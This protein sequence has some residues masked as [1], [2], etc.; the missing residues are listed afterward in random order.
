MKKK[1][2][3]MRLLSYPNWKQKLP[4][5]NIVYKDV[6][7]YSLRLNSYERALMDV[8][9]NFYRQ[10]FSL[11][12]A[13]NHFKVL[14]TKLAKDIFIKAALKRKEKILYLPNCLVPY[15]KKK[16]KTE[17]TE[18]QAFFEIL[19]EQAI[20]QKHTNPMIPIVK[21]IMGDYYKPV[22]KLVNK[23]SKMKPI[24]VLQKTL[25]PAAYENQARIHIQKLQEDICLSNIYGRS[26]IRKSVP[27]SI[28]DDYG[29]G[30]WVSK[31]VSFGSNRLFI[32]SNNNKL[33]D[34]ALEHM[35]YFN[36]YPGY[37]YFY[38]TVVGDGKQ[39][40]SFDNG[41]TYL[42]NGWAM[43]AMCHSMNSAYSTSL[44]IEGATIC[45]HLLKKN[46]DKGLEDVYIYLLGKYPKSK[47][48]EYMLDYTQYPGRYMSYVLGAFA[49]E[50]V[51]HSDFAHNPIDYLNTIKSINCGDFFAL[52]TPKM[53]RKIAKTNITAKVAKKFAY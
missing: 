4:F 32:Y 19:L 42:I 39:N 28:V 24:R 6:K 45:R 43:Y 38:N 16:I 8:Q 52:Y 41:A 29:Y 44:L 26:S 23:Y 36:V 7:R 18:H 48:I 30:E 33:T 47:A 12:Q 1:E 14:R 51:M 53:Q 35:I 40:L 25:K 20:N 3:I 46:L 9:I 15:F 22:I 13:M 50:L 5:D 11:L 34:V 21:T 17:F 31:N 10:H 2:S 49:T 37:G 27:I